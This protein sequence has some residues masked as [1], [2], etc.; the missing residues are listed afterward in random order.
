MKVHRFNEKMNVIGDIIAKKRNEQNLSYASLS[1]KLQP[2]G[3]C[4][5]KND[6]FLIE[7]N[8]RIVR[9][10]ELIALIQILDINYNEI[11]DC[12]NIQKEP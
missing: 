2:L 7:K 9:D 8:K 4:L 12:L 1:N 10:F 5:Y 6:L 3:V 11:K